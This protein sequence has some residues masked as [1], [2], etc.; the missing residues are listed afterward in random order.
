MSDEATTPVAEKP[1]KDK[2]IVNRTALR[3]QY[4]HREPHAV[5][6]K[7]GILE[8][9]DD[10]KRGRKYKIL[11]GKSLPNQEEFNRL[12]QQY[13]GDDFAGGVKKAKEAA[14]VTA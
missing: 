9:I 7:A 8:R 12:G 14:A 11:D 13:L 5:L 2:S 6:V 3:R 10:G 1:A 4:M